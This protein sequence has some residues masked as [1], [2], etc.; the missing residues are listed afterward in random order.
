MFGLLAERSKAHWRTQS[1]LRFLNRMLFMAAEPDR[2][3][4]VM[5]RF[6]G[7]RQPLIERFYAGTSLLKDKARIL[8]GRPPVAILRA[9]KC[10]PESSAR[11]HTTEV[12][13]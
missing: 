7:L 11:A 3:W 4:F 9:L 10:L 1:F 12:F 2:R 5:Q 13:N 6:Y 8:T